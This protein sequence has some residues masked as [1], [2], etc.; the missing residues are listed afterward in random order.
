MMRVAWAA[1][2]LV[3]SAFAQSADGAPGI[4][5]EWWTP[6]FNARVRLEPCAEHLCGTIVW[7]WNERPTDIADTRPL[8][9]RRILVDM[10]AQGQG[11]WDSGRIYNPEDGR[12]Y[13]ASLTLAAP[14]NLV[15]EG[16]ALFFCKS[17][18]WRRADRAAC[19][20]VAR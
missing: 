5:D 13:D 16:C 18:V 4:F 14:N 3:L 6:G 17:Q 7:V 11:R 10:R 2:V 19:P 9:G 8:V 15:V 20:P 1:F 12:H